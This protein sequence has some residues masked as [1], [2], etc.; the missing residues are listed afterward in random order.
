MASL[1]AGLNPAAKITNEAEAKAAARASAVSILLGVVWGA[2]GLFY[3]MSPEGAEA[4]RQAMA[5]AETPETAGMAEAMSGAVVG[6]TGVT[7]VIQLIFMLIQWAKP[8]I[9]IPIIFLLLVIYGLL[10]SLLDVVMAD[11]LAAMMGPQ[12]QYAAWMT[13]GSIAVLAVQALLH[14]AGIRGASAL[15]KF[16]RAAA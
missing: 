7:I 5:A 3:L 2:I 14:V 13:Y 1:I 16:R 15:A 11:Q 12:P 9:A 4:T 10:A 6:I 8:N